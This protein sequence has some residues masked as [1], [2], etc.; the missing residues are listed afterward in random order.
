MTEK[1]G[2][3]IPITPSEL[4]YKEAYL[5]LFNKLSDMSN[6]IMEIQRRAEDIATAEALVKRC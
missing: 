1:K 3:E 5:Y 6:E 2:N 4:N